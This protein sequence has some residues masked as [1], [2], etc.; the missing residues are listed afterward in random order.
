MNGNQGNTEAT[1]EIA[2]I[3]PLQEV[4]WSR[5]DVI[6]VTLGVSLLL[7]FLAGLF[8]LARRLRRGKLPGSV[9]ETAVREHW[10]VQVS[11]RLAALPDHPRDFEEVRNCT[12]ELGSLLREVIGQLTQQH[13]T[14]LTSNEM[15]SRI[16]PLLESSVAQEVEHFLA[17]AEL[18][19]FAKIDLGNDI[20]ISGRTLVARLL[21]HAMEIERQRQA[22]SMPYGSLGGDVSP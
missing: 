22:E 20:Y 11:R 21:E 5:Q 14:E 6:L 13:A 7:L 19:L 16:L 10:A 3:K 15:R 1:S 4:H 9:T 17:R 2:D 18:V 12:F 8:W